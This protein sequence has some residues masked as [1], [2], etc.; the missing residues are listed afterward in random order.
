MLG[1]FPWGESL[2]NLSP[3][4]FSCLQP[5]QL[6]LG[7]VEAYWTVSAEG[8]LR[9]R[10]RSHRP[11]SD[12]GSCTGGPPLVRDSCGRTSRP[13]YLMARSS[14]LV[15]NEVWLLQGA[16]VSEFLSRVSS[17]T[18]GHRPL[19]T[20]RPPE[21]TFCSGSCTTI[22]TVI[23]RI[24]SKGDFL[25]GYKSLGRVGRRH[26]GYQFHIFAG[27]LC[28]RGW[29][30]GPLVMFQKLACLTTEGLYNKPHT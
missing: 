28:S 15:T 14:T 17:L 20:G 3:T 23:S 18:I 1:A 16:Y 27:L 9:A 26:S 6:P 10:R 8:D 24:I 12:S 2:E 5:P 30:R 4:S 7:L 25:G 19:P 11:V 21:N 29:C 13:S 22:R